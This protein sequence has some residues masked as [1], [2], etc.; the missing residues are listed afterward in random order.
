MHTA[1]QI[2][3]FNQVMVIFSVSRLY[4]PLKRNAADIPVYMVMGVSEIIPAVHAWSFSL[5]ASF[6][7]D[8]HF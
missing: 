7:R 1:F 4:A 3:A 2:M 5:T 8:A 6:W